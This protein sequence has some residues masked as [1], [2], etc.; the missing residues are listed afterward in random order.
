MNRQKWNHK[1]IR[2]FGCS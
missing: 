1:N 2:V